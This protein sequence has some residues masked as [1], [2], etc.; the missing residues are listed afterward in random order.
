MFL[1]LHFYDFDQAKE[2][3]GIQPIL[4]FLRGEGEK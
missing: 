2:W 3:R 1:F 4:V